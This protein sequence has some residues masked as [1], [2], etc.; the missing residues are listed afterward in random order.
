[1]AAR[2]PTT[3]P[4]TGTTLLEEAGLAFVPLSEE[5]G[6]KL[7]TA[8]SDEC[9]D[10]DEDSVLEWRTVIE[11]DA[12]DRASMNVNVLFRFDIR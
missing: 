1:M 11:M 4:A 8:T 2:L 10:E 3:P 9:E 12:R 5:N 6:A 7:V